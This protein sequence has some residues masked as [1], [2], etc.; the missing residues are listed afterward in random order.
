MYCA[1]ILRYVSAG[2]EPRSAGP[3]PNS[4]TSSEASDVSRA[5][6]LCSWTL[7]TAT[8]SNK[9][10]VRPAHHIKH[11][12]HM[13]ASNGSGERENFSGAQITS[14]IASQVK[15]IEKNVSDANIMSS[16]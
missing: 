9:R 10:A 5:L 1:I 6:A 14:A 8:P 2:I 3:T 11:Y 12:A 16:K 13:A 4:E 15:Q 7:A